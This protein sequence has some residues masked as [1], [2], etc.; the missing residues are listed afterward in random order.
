MFMCEFVLQEM[1]VHHFWTPLSLKSLSL[2]KIFSLYKVIKLILNAEN[3]EAQ[4]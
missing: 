2:T 3:R 4:K 1:K